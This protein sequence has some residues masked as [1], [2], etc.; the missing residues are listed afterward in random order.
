MRLAW[1]PWLMIAF[2]AAPI[3]SAADGPFDVRLIEPFEH[4]QVAAGS[5]VS[6]AWDAANV[7]ASVEEWEAFLS[8][9]AGRTYPLRLTPHLD[10]S[11][12]RF[13]WKV[14]NLPGVE[15]SIL[16]RFGNEHEERRFLFP[17]RMRITGVA[18]SL[19]FLFRARA[20][21][22]AGRGEAAEVDGE[23]VIGW[24][25]G[26]RDGSSLREV[27]ASDALHFDGRVLDVSPQDESVATLGSP[28][29]REDPL[30][31]LT[32]VRQVVLERRHH[33]NVVCSGESAANILL[34][35]RRRNI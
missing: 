8:I 4:T 10:A 2:A 1:V 30:G 29:G 5:T 14:P 7:P 3:A 24:V 23:G 19:A 26:A 16:L 11:I 34:I 20:I 28:V 17:A 32:F 33:S 15:V 31:H 22:A 6:M 13:H 27:V 9:D 25:E 12:H 35:S 21:E 18:P